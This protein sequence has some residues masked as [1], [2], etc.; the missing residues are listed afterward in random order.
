MAN[1]L[2]TQQI[3][4]TNRRKNI[5]ITLGVVVL[6]VG[7]ITVMQGWWAGILIVLIGG[8]ATFYTVFSLGKSIDVRIDKLSKLLHTKERWFG[9]T[10]ARHQSRVVT[11]N[12]F[13][14]KLSFHSSSRK[15]VTQRY[16]L[17]FHSDG[18]AIRIADGIEGE[19]GAMAL[20]D[21]IVNLCLSP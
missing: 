18:K 5:S 2:S 10:Y 17:N 11:S 19:D 20:M 4:P 13:K 8:Y 16:A 7:I 9:F 1:I 21:T 6:G 3:G 15:K 14:T 12:Q